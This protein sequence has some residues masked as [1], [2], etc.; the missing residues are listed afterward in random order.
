MIGLEQVVEFGNQ[1]GSGSIHVWW[2]FS[3][4]W[5]AC[6]FGLVKQTQ[7]LLHTAL[8]ISVVSHLLIH[9]Y[10]SHLAVCT[11]KVS[12]VGHPKSRQEER[13]G[14][15]GCERGC[16]GEFWGISRVR[17]GQS[18]A[19]RAACLILLESLRFGS[20][21]SCSLARACCRFYIGRNGMHS[22]GFVLDLGSLVSEFREV[23]CCI[24][25]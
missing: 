1:L 5:A 14:T 25:S 7:S 13:A 17:R 18:L 12:D 6:V 19:F 22:L 21:E 15:Q 20:V 10:A 4:F 16:Q 8:E 9:F 24:R 3:W 11:E 2:R 23:Q